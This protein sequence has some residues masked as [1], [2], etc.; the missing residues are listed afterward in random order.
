V[1]TDKIR[2]GKYRQLYRSEQ[3]ITGKQ[4]AANIYARGH[5]AVGRQID[6]LVLDG[7]RKQAEQ[8]SSPQG[9]VISHSVGGGTGSGFT[10]L[11]MQKL[12]DFYGKKSKIQFVIYPAPRASTTVV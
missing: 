12:S 3:A 7:I 5:Y 1:S 6:H 2:T 8:C 4:D 10:S 11:L 9:F